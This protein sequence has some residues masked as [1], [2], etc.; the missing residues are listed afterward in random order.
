MTFDQFGKDL[1]EFLAESTVNLGRKTTKTRRAFLDTVQGKLDSFLS[2]QEEAKSDVATDN[3]PKNPLDDRLVCV[4]PKNP[5]RALDV[6]K[7]VTAMTPSES[8]R[9]D[10][11]TGGSPYVKGNIDE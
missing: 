5:R 7:G 9:A 1:L 6:G 8:M 3:K 2:E 4:K 11:E 10:E